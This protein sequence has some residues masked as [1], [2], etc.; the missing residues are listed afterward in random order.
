LLFRRA[1]LVTEQII[2]WV[3][4]DLFLDGGVSQQP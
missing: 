4:A 3:R 1:P 2:L